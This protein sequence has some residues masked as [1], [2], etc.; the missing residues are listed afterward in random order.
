MVFEP[1]L[2]WLRLKTQPIEQAY[3]LSGFGMC[4]PDA[5]RDFKPDYR[6]SDFDS[7]DLSKLYFDHKFINQCVLVVRIADTMLSSILINNKVTF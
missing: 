1:G 2:R 3:H 7:N 6:M 5:R 4:C